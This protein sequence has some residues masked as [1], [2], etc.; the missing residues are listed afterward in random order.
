MGSRKPIDR[1][2]N[3]QGLRG[4]RKEQCHRCGKWFYWDELV[5]MYSQ[6]LISKAQ[7]YIPWSCYSS[8]WWTSTASDNGAVGH[9]DSRFT[10][11][12]NLNQARPD[13]FGGVQSWEGSGRLT[14][15]ALDL[16]GF[17][18]ALFS[19]RFG[20]VQWTEYPEMTVSLYLMEP[21]TTEHL[22]VSGTSSRLWGVLDISA[23]D[24]SL[25]PIVDVALDNEAGEWWVDHMQLEL[26][27]DT[28]GRILPT[29][30]AATVVASDRKNSVGVE[31]FCKD[32]R[33]R[34]RPIYNNIT[35]ENDTYDD[36]HTDYGGL[37][38][39]E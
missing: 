36:I 28:P 3:Y 1:Q 6:K 27:V 7:N 16:T 12:V 33:G 11:V 13:E 17:T 29:G 32:C 26:D 4:E 9:G 39:A 5:R 25:T 21:D 35:I 19:T 8:S 2:V 20:P 31:V 23:L 34:V 24:T 22:V 38:G 14:G 30:G 18:K 37:I 15:Q 10:Y